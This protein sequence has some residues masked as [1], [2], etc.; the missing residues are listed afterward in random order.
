M[1]ISN[2]VR[3]T[4][5]V[6]TLAAAG[7]PVDGELYEFTFTGIVNDVDGTP[8][9][10]WGDVV[11]GSP[12]EVSY[13]I[14]S[15]TPDL[16]GTPEEGFYFIESATVTMDGTG[17]TTDLGYLTVDLV[18]NI[19]LQ[20]VQLGL[21][22]LPIAGGASGAVTL[23]DD[24]AIESDALPLSLNLDD[25]MFN[26]FELATAKAFVRG[27]VLGFSGQVLPAPGACIMV[28]LA[29]GVLGRR[30]RRP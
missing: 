2:R 24:D 9:S 27:D 30:Q 26:E 7:S 23:V 22:D 29:A 11:V 15:R 20:E 1:S 12:W 14:D 13:I 8:P 25:F 19:L 21:P 5:V 4:I 10:F 3:A 28:V 16:I 17:V 6:L 18:S